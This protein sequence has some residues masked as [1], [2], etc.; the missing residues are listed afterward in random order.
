VPSRVLLGD[1]L[2][3][4]TDLLENEDWL[5]NETWVIYVDGSST[6]EHGRGGVVLVTLDGEELCSS[7]KLEFRITKNEAEYEAVLVALSLACEMEA[8]FVELRSDP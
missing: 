5:G 2:V 3:E 6:K 4:F 8:K 1:F 7:L